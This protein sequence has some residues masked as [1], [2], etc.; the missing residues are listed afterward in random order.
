MAPL[1]TALALSVAA[2]CSTALAE[3][4]RPPPR[5]HG[6]VPAAAA[7]TDGGV[8]ASPGARYLESLSPASREALVKDGQVILDTRT[9]GSGPSLVKAAVRFARSRADTY[10]LITQP[11]EQH[12]F[13]PHVEVSRAVGERTELGE[14]EDFEVSFLFTF[15]YRTQHWFYPEEDRV[16]W[17]LDPTG[18]D[19]LEAQLGYWQLYELDDHTTLAEY[20]THIVARGALLNFFR[21]LGER[22]AINEALTAFRKHIDTSPKVAGRPAAVPAA[23]AATGAVAP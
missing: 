10:S 20:G 9:T 1:R 17:N 13:L 11:A 2:L 5:G 7:P 3:D 23:G 12:T 6:A 18:G 19:G 4:P 21:S 16:E 15:K 22:G 14:R 8:A